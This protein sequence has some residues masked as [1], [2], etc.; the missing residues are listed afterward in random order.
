VTEHKPRKDRELLDAAKKIARTLG[1]SMA[2]PM[3]VW[4]FIGF[5]PLVPSIVDVFGMNGLRIP[6]GVV[7]GGLM[8][9][10]F[11]FEDF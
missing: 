8:L 6:T 5:I 4:L 2:A 7:I 9:A 11:G 3:F 10:A 1:I